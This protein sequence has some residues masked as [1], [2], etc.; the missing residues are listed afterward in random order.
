MNERKASL[1][2]LN[3]KP[4]SELADILNKNPMEGYSVHHLGGVVF[5]EKTQ[6]SSITFAPNLSRIHVTGTTKENLIAA[7]NTVAK[8]SAA[9]DLG[10]PQF[11]TLNV[12]TELEKNEIEDSQQ[13]GKI[14][15]PIVTSKP[16]KKSFFD[17]FKPASAD[18]TVE[19]L[20]DNWVIDSDKKEIITIRFE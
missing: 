9:F 19:P 1:T 18:K 4:F 14:P 12:P 3:A 20:E 11:T 17:F 10:S 16:E 7:L 5:L 13:M 2:L 15:K 8:L 6:Q